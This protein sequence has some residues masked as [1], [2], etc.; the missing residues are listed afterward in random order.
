MDYTYTYVKTTTG[1][2]T[3]RAGSLEEANDEAHE[4]LERLM[5]YGMT[6]QSGISETS[7]EVGDLSIVGVDHPNQDDH[8]E[9]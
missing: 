5:T 7:A 9:E 2:I 1:R 3:V 6:G 4:Q 8:E